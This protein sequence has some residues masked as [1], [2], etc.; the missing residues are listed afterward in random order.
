MLSQ[1]CKTTFFFLYDLLPCPQTR[2]WLTSSTFK[3]LDILNVKYMILWSNSWSKVPLFYHHKNIKLCCYKTQQVLS[4]FSSAPP[5]SSNAS[6]SFRSL[7]EAYLPIPSQAAVTIQDAEY[8]QV[9]KGSYCCS[10]FP[11]SSTTPSNC[12]NSVH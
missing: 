6:S 9:N 11:F 10:L 8:S 3:T 1:K 2:M 4:I 7:V 12:C 5:S